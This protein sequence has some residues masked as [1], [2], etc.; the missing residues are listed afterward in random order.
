[1][2][3]VSVKKREKYPELEK[4]WMVSMVLSHV[5]NMLG[6]DHSRLGRLG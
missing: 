6:T 5:G 2:E 3:E 1:M 4:M